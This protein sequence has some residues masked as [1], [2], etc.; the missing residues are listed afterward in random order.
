M[1]IVTFFLYS[2]KEKIILFQ[3]N[4]ME[5]TCILKKGKTFTQYGRLNNIF[6]RFFLV[7]QLSPKH[8]NIFSLLDQ[9]VWFL[10]GVFTIIIQ[11]ID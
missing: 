4:E 6:F 10:F 2:K 11:L 5:T 9:F 3:T 8:T 1:K 7:Y